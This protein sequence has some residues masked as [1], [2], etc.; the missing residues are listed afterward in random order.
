MV[1]ILSWPQCGTVKWGNF[2]RWGNFG[3]YKN[4]YFEH[5]FLPPEEQSGG[6]HGRQ[7]LFAICNLF[8]KEFH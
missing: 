2:G 7:R 4:F 8:Q 3:H 6:E 5:Y 1:A